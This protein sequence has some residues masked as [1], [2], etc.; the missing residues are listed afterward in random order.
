MFDA[1]NVADSGRYRFGEHTESDDVDTLLAGFSPE[2][3]ICAVAVVDSQHPPK[4]RR[5]PFPRY[6]FPRRSAKL[7]TVG[8]QPAEFY[9]GRESHSLVMFVFLHLITSV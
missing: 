6:S 7:V 9:Q 3:G 2:A 1:D 5:Q 4:I 8:R